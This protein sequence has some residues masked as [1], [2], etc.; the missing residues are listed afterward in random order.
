MR[1]QFVGGGVREY[2]TL[3]VGEMEPEIGAFLSHIGQNLLER[4]EAVAIEAYDVVIIEIGDQVASIASRKHEGVGTAAPIR[5]SLPP[6][7]SIVCVPDPPF[8]MLSV[9]LPNANRPL[10]V[11]VRFS[12]FAGSV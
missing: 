2:Q 8:M 12:K 9:S 4:R 5:T 1:L 6:R 11:T 10:P 7:P 3:A